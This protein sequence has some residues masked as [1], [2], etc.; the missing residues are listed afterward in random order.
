MEI[1][2]KVAVD[3]VWSLTRFRG[4]SLKCITYGS[5]KRLEFPINSFLAFNGTVAIQWGRLIFVLVIP[6]LFLNNLP[7]RIR[8]HRSCRDSLAL[9]YYFILTEFMERVLFSIVL[10]LFFSVVDVNTLTLL[11]NTVNTN[12]IC[13]SFYRWIKFSIRGF[14]FHAFISYFNDNLDN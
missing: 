7:K 12:H 2:C 4:R 14:I 8:L 11:D 6:F 1:E 10:F 9:V 13:A 3:S 5:W